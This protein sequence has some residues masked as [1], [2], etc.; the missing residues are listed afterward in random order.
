VVRRGEPLGTTLLDQIAKFLAA[1]ALQR[2]RK[3]SLFASYRGYGLEPWQKLRIEEM[4]RTQL[5]EKV[6]IKSLARACSLSESHFARCFRSSFGTSVHQW[7]I[8]LRI[9]RAKT[10][11]SETRKPLVEVAWLSGFCDQA[12]FTRSFSR[13]ERVSPSRWR[14]FHATAGDFSNDRSKSS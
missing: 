2:Y 6:T 5:E 7:L 12:A 1:Q 11:L 13:I 3:N 10:L 14:R 9:E 8:Q 4:S